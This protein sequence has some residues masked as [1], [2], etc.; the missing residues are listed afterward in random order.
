MPLEE[1]LQAMTER[2]YEAERARDQ[3]ADALL[4]ALARPPERDALAQVVADLT[5]ER[6]GP[7]PRHRRGRHERTDVAAS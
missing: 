2:A 1:A 5:A 6:Y 4:L 7:S 3:L